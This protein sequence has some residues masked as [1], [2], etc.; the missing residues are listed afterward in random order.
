MTDDKMVV[1]ENISE[2]TSDNGQAIRRVRY[3]L[4]ETEIFSMVIILELVMSKE[5]LIKIF[6]SLFK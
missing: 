6:Y 1:I 5:L 3:H 4:V 2:E